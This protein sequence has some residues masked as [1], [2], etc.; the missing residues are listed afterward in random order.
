MLTHESGSSAFL[1]VWRRHRREIRRVVDFLIVGGIAFVVDAAVYNLLVFGP[2]RFSFGELPLPAKAISIGLGTVASFV[3]NRLLTYRDRSSRLTVLKFLVFCGLN[4]IA[5]IIQLGILGFSRYV[6]GL[7]SVLADNISGTLIGQ[8]AAMAFRYA[9][10]GRL[11]FTGG[12]ESAI[13]LG[14][15]SLH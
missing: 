14:A 13:S 4:V 12:K 11:V 10:Y 8:A 3:G 9:T 2:G 7:H 15:P 1:K 6:L 5:I